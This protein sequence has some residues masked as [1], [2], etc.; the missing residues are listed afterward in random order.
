MSEYITVPEYAALRNCSTKN[1]Y[2]QIY[3]SRA[4]PGVSHW[5]RSG[6][7]YLLYVDKQVAQ[8][9]EVKNATSKRKKTSLKVFSK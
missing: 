7:A 8:T 2:N 1:I 9:K 6:K 4:M 5:K 3:S